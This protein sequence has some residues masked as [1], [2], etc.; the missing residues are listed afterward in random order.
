MSYHFYLGSIMTQPAHR[1]HSHC[2]RTGTQAHSL[3]ITHN[4]PSFSHSNQ[5]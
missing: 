2:S 1:L 4:S 5:S 3:Q